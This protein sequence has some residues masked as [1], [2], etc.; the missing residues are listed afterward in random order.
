MN[1]KNENINAASFKKEKLAKTGL[2]FNLIHLEDTSYIGR[3]LACQD[4]DA[5]ASR[6]IGKSRDMIVGMMPPKLV[7]MM[8]NLAIIGQNIT[9][10]KNPIVIYDPFCGL[11]TTLIEAANMGIKHV[12][13]SDIS[14][15]MVDS[16]TKSLN[17]FIRVERMWQERIRLAGGTPNKDF[18]HFESK[19]FELDAS[20]VEKVFEKYG[21]S[22]TALIVSE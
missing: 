17:E 21:V 12:F 5:Y 11:G 13:G 1:Q 2:E 10:S 22:P 9:K 16:S 19:F 6:D 14:R 20:H 7:Q 8:I 15:D 3:T 18:T 4:I